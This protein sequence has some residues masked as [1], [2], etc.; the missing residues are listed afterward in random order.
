[1]TYIKSPKA[2]LRSKYLKYLQISFI[3]SLLL[4]IA[5]F[6][7]F[8]EVNMPKRAPNN[9]QE[10]FIVEN[11]QQ[12]TQETKLPPPEKS[13][14]LIE[15]IPDELLED[16]E[17]NSTEININEQL[18]SQPPPVSGKHRAIEEEADYIFEFV[19]Q[20]PE[21]I[22]GIAAIQDRVVYPELAIRAG[23]EGKVVVITQIDEFG[24]IMSAQILKS[25]G[26]GCDE[27]ALTA[28]LNTKFLPGKQ[29]GKAVKVEMKIP[30]IFKLQS[31]N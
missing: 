21:P 3:V 16:I 30:V 5:A 22:G 23:I 18:N 2:D 8:P 28:V 1:M 6:K 24:N 15:T 13:P 12:T 25:L 4:L 27:A 7:Y 9:S 17:I 29:R 14:I 19:E 26:A 31:V 20:L 11:I 10:L